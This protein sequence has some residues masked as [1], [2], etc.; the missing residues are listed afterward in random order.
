MLFVS[1][2]ASLCNAAGNTEDTRLNGKCG[3]NDFVGAPRRI[4]YTKTGCDGPTDLTSPPTGGCL[5][6]TTCANSLIQAPDP[7]EFHC[8]IHFGHPTWIGTFPT[9]VAPPHCGDL[10]HD[11]EDIGFYT[12]DYDCGLFPADIVT[13]TVS[14]SCH[15]PLVAA[16]E[17]F[18]CTAQPDG[19]LMWVGNQPACVAPKCD[20]LDVPGRLLKPEILARYTIDATAC[21]DN[22]PDADTCVVT[23]I[24]QNDA[25]PVSLSENWRCRDGLW[26]GKWPKCRPCHR[27]LNAATNDPLDYTCQ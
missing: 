14:T 4:T 18:T 7:E 2:F 17:I 6:T 25:L 9:C 21:D 27:V 13:C 26:R 8:V 15:W 16:D 11:L 24:C 5:I 10:G 3:T 23:A 12:Y 20:H 22:S 1:L 19:S